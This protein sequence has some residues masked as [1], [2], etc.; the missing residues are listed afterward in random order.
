MPTL[1]LLNPQV[2]QAPESVMM[3]QRVHQFHDLDISYF[4]RIKAIWIIPDYLQ[5]TL[6]VK[7]KSRVYMCI[8]KLAK[9]F[10]GLVIPHKENN[11]VYLS[12]LQSAHYLL[13]VSVTQIQQQLS[14]VTI[15]ADF[16]IYKFFNVSQ[17]HKDFDH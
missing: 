1:I 2:Y 10:P 8:K 14:R 11:K 17:D 15:S 7:T 5:I 6:Y 13:Q 4:Y 12:Y 9:N 16:S 3:N